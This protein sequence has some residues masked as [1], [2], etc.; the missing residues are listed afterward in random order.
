MKRLLLFLLLVALG[1]GGL[2][3]ALGNEMAAATRPMASPGTGDEAGPEPAGPTG[4]AE[5]RG[6]TEPA[7]DEP[8]RPTVPGTGLPIGNG[9]TV[10]QYG[11]IDAPHYREVPLGDGRVRF[12]ETYVLRAADSQPIEAGRQMLTGVAV[13]LY[14]KGKPAALLTAAQA[15]VELSRD[16]NG[17]P[18]LRE[19][20]AIDLRTAVFA[21]LADTRAAGLRLEVERVLV[22]IDEDAIELRT[23]DERT[24]VAVTFAGEPNGSLHGLGLQARL[25][26]SGKSELQRLDFDLLHEPVVESSGVTVRARG[27]L[28]YTEHVG[29]GLGMLQVDDDVRLDLERAELFRDLQPRGERAGAETHGAIRADQLLGWV[30]RDGKAAG[31]SPAAHGGMTWRML[32]LVGSPTEITIPGARLRAPQLSVVAGDD[33]LPFAITAHGG[34]TTFEQTD[35]RSDSP[36]A[37][38]ANGSSPHRVHLVRPAGTVGLAHRAFGFPEWTLGPLADMTVVTFEGRAN[39]RDAQRSIEA[40]KGLR[41]FPPSP[42]CDQTEVFGFGKV[43]VEQ[44]GRRPQDP[45]LVATGND[46][47]HLVATPAGER[48]Q[49]GPAVPQPDAAPSV[50]ARWRDHRYE[51]QRG[52]ARL[53]GSGTCAT[54]HA[55][56]VAE[57]HLR[58]PAGGIRGRV[59]A[60]GAELTA[61]HHLD[62]TIADDELRSLLV[63]GL[64]AVATIAR[65]GETLRAEAPRLEQLGP[66]SLVLLPPGTDASIWRGLADDA[67]LPRL[68]RV[69]G[70]APQTAAERV[71]TRAPRIEIHHLGGHDALVV[72]LA[73]ERQP[74]HASA[75]ITRPGRATPTTIALDATRLQILPFAVPRAVRQ[76]AFGGASPVVAALAEDLLGSAW[77]VVD[78]VR[79]FVAHDSGFGDVTGSG[80]RLLLS[81][82]AAAG[83]FLG[84][85]ETLTPAHVTRER[86]GRTI[87]ATGAQ[88][89]FWQGDER[90]LIARRAFPDRST[91][92]LP[93]VVL[94]HAGDNGPLAHVRAV[95]DGD[96]DVAAANVQFGG[97][98]VA[99]ALHADGS[100]DPEGMHVA[101]RFLA[102]QGDPETFEIVRMTGR[103]VALDW[104]QLTAKSAE[105]ELDLRWNRC[106]VHDPAGARVRL[107]NGLEFV[108]PWIEANYDTLAIH[109]FDGRVQQNDA[110]VAN[111]R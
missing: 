8:Q 12:E 81:Q 97:P 78:D 98:V 85:A 88:V 32:R 79:S 104:S 103:E 83:L 67:R 80:K 76:F 9:A 59:T 71:D 58:A 50:Q 65:G 51:V 35:L 102:M 57:I 106:T 64:P 20:K 90:H 86:A 17:R 6:T 73:D 72:A 69:V 30:R 3:L 24:P 37:G 110:P 27:R 55:G 54:T 5:R 21:T 43:R 13:T 10:S 28:H 45:P 26:R 94:H 29:E 84:D 74:A 91:F 89:R 2:W 11:P 4:A 1:A 19:D 33:G 100:D 39:L 95:C 92:V 96:I 18:S 44:A 38:L 105:A 40:S 66:A 111:D 82:S 56:G 36:L 77:L 53:E 22:N 101:A 49:L 68:T 109:C 108:S 107:P 60:D 70:A 99:Q 63:A 46:G 52:A 93:T 61:I 75:E 14:D 62:A 16:A 31:G 15:F 7:A 87:A 48:L 42:G 34:E 23:P 47:L 25:P 41:V